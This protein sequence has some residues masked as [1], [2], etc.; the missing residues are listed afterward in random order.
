MVCGITKHKKHKPGKRRSSRRE[1]IVA[2]SHSLIIGVERGLHK[3]EQLV[4]LC[5]YLLTY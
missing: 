2:G 3:E 1:W 5:T 4:E